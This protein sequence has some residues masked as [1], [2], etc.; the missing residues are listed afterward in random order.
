[1]QATSPNDPGV[2]MTLRVYQVDRYGTVTQDRGTVKVLNSD[3]P[4][5]LSTAYPPCGCQTCRATRRGGA[6]NTPPNGSN[7]TALIDI[8]TIRETIE[9]I[10]G[11]EGAEAPPSAPIEVET[12]TAVLRG[13]LELLIPEVAKRAAR[14][15]KDSVSRYCALACI[16]EARRKLDAEPSPRFGGPAGHARRLARVLR[17]LC[18]HYENAGHAQR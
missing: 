10:L 15:P 16:G 12:G 17:A 5:S 3:E 1:M 14:L 2:K 6:V 8:A 11:P 4:L 18:D 9:R 7:A 13:H